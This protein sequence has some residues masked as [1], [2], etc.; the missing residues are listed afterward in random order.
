VRPPLAEPSS[1]FRPGSLARLRDL[2]GSEVEAFGGKAATLGLMLRHDLTVLDGYA[3]GADSYGEAVRTAGAE[4]LVEE[5]WSAPPG[6]AGETSATRVSDEIRRRLAMVDVEPLAE[7]VIAGFDAIDPGATRLIARSSATV[8]DSANL[9]FAGQ[10]GSFSCARDRAALAQAIAE[11]WASCTAPHVGAYRSALS[12]RAG[13]SSEFDRVRMG[14]VVQP[15]KRF[16]LAGLLFSQHVTVPVRGWMLLEYLD[17]DPA[18]LV[19]GE[20]T[21]HRCR[22]NATTRRVLW[23][24]RVSDR[25]ILAA[26]Q[27]DRLVGGAAKLRVLLSGEVDIEWGV[28]EQTPI[29]LQC[30]PATTTAAPDV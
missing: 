16:S 4:A 12:G 30:R 23:E 8:E 17:A 25:P 29:F 7:G 5:F 18:R 1:A 3:I 20:V 24:R 19:A 15:H 21:P 2:E 27:L 6:D 9:S 28:L 10:F 14:V 22:V 26:E 13:G 11:V